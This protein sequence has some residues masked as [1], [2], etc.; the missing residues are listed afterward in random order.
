MDLSE[1]LQSWTFLLIMAGLLC[2][3]VLFVP[4][5]IVLVI[6]FVTRRANRDNSANWK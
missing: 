1:F 4:M 3:L 2:F 6:I 5:F